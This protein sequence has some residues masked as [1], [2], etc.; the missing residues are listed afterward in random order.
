M[1]IVHFRCGRGFNNRH[2]CK[3]QIYYNTC[4][5]YS[6]YI[7][8]D[9]TKEDGLCAEDKR[10]VGM[11][12]NSDKDGDRSNVRMVVVMMRMMKRKMIGDTDLPS[13]SYS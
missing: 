12:S 4:N 3:A 11:M 10:S 2:K 7:E 13:S 5:L 1:N 8:D 6:T 9:S